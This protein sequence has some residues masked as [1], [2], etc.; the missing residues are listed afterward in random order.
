MLKG[1]YSAVSAMNLSEFRQS[2]TAKNLANVSKPGYRQAQVSF[3]TIEAGA[4]QPQQGTG[5]GVQGAKMYHRFEPGTLEHT[6]RTLDVTIDGP[7]F[8]KVDGPDGPLYTRDGVFHLTHDNRL[9][10]GG[11]YPVTGVQLPANAAESKIVIGPQGDVTVDGQ[12]GGRIEIVEF[13]D[14]QRLENVSDT[15]FRAPEDMP[16]TPSTSRLVQGT[17]ELSNV[18]VADELVRMI[19]TQRQHEASQRALRSISDSIEKRINN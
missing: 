9:V 18:N 11:G 4:E 8:L 17:R 14:N 13:A 1:L 7:G 19:L 3:E 12:A 15:L 6:G 10:T 16:A 2:V 5:L